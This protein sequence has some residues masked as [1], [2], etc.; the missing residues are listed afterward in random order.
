M[1]K[2]YRP[3]CAPRYLF[4]SLIILPILL[5]I[6]NAQQRPKANWADIDLDRKVEDTKDNK[7]TKSTATVQPATLDP[8]KQKSIWREPAWYVA[9]GGS[10]LDI[11]G[12]V[13][14]IDGKRVREGNS[15]FARSDG[16]LSL[17]R[18]LPVTAVSLFLQHHYY[19]N[20]KHRKIA[21]I[22]MVAVGIVRGAFGGV[23]GFGMR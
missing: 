1:K 10:A 19:K 13:A 14:T 17:A 7:D 15:L 4:C 8:E 2:H 22:S 18:A 6:A 23:R 16:K 21:I 9:L 3:S 20:P 5:T 12:S 11:A